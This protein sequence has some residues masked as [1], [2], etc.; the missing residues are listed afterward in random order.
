MMPLSLF[1]IRN[2]CGRQPDHLLR[3]RRTDRW[4]VLRRPL[5]PA[6]GGLLAAGGRAGDDPISVLMFFL[7]PRFGKVA[8]GTGPRLPMSA[9]PIVG[10]VGLLLL[11]RVGSTP[12]T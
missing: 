9:G 8:S 4:A 7:S 11:L 1:R 2:F 12:T 6:G 3:L 10:G 5:P